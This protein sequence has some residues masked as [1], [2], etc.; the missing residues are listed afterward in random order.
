M[1]EVLVRQ[2]DLR[3]PEI[4][5]AFRKLSLAAERSALLQQGAGGTHQV[6]PHLHDHLRDGALDQQPGVRVRAANVYAPCQ[7]LTAGWREW[8]ESDGAVS[9][10]RTTP[11]AQRACR[12]S[13]SGET[14]T[15]G[16]VGRSGGDLMSGE[17]ERRACV[18]EDGYCHRRRVVRDHAHLR[19]TTSVSAHPEFAAS[20]VQHPDNVMQLQ[21]P[22]LFVVRHEMIGGR[23][24][25]RLVLE[26]MQLDV[27]RG[28]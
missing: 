13:R 18:D 6:D 23:S 12:C 5:S 21:C 16:R 19:T 11:V 14:P 9:Q 26:H 17:R 3:P 24:K 28:G 2:V 15:L 4:V 1:V 27:L 25:A 7:K 8:Q 22:W 20:G 10:Q